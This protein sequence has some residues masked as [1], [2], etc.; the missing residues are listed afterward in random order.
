MPS[1][2]HYNA[3]GLVALGVAALSYGVWVWNRATGSTVRQWYETKYAARV[4]LILIAGW[5][6]I[7]NLPF[8]PF[9]SLYV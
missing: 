2:I 5:F 8:A 1:A 7:R 9:T 3:L 6:T 4:S